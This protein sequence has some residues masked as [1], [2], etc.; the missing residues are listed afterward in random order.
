MSS[1]QAL[2]T[3]PIAIEIH[4]LLRELDPA[5]WR[6]DAEHALRAKMEDIESRLVALR[7]VL[8]P[9]EATTDE[10]LTHLRERIAE[11]D[12][13]V[14]AHIADFKQRADQGRDEWMAFRA[15]LTPAYEQLATVLRA[16]A[17]H[18]PSLRPTNYKRNLMHVSF[19]FL[20]FAVVQLL[21]NATWI[22][23]LATAFVVYAWSMELI[24]RRSP[25]F[26]ERLMAVY[27]PVAHAHE[28]H[29]VNS[30]TWY[31]SALFLLSLSGSYLVCSVA[32]LVLAVGDP[33]AAIVGRRFGRTKLINGRS[34]EG[35]LAFVGVATLVTGVLLG[36]FR[37]DLGVAAGF[38][39]ALVG[40]VA[41]AV[42][43]LLSRRID[44]NFTIPLVSGLAA[45]AALLLLG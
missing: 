43:E 30:A 3:R 18:V 6:S 34:L 31:A 45:W 15:R 9:M 28:W 4:A 10:T 19:G 14:R 40:G 44:D 41:G 22:V 33:M 37:P 29:R 25:A 7:K 12:V 2:A 20:A 21:P 35:S 17:I 39:V 32:V 24:R 26:N 38:G 13:L 5:R 27:G 36:L 8:E 23:G 42:A 11:L 16:E 1:A